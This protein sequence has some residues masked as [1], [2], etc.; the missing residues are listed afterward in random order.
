MTT[1]FYGKPKYWRKF[2]A[3]FS[4][5]LHKVEKVPLKG[6]DEVLYWWQPLKAT[7]RP[8]HPALCATLSTLWRGEER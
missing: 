7:A 6:A 4:S 8:P 2:I 3:T 1:C 5:L